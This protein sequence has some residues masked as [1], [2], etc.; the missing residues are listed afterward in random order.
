MHAAVAMTSALS[1][2]PSDRISSGRRQRTREAIVAAAAKALVERGPQALTVDD[3]LEAS[4]VARATFYK[5]FADKHEVTREVI[6][7]MWRRAADRY[8]GF[9]AG[10]PHTRASLRAW[11]EETAQTWREHYREVA[12][13]LREMPAEVVQASDGYL[14]DFAGLLVGDGGQWRCAQCEAKIRA[15]LLIG[16]LERAMLDLCRG[17]W[18][19]PEP[20]LLD[21]LTVLW[22]QALRAP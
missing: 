20:A 14:D 18:P 6:T 16:Q 5:H 9:S 3:I 21:T 12:A 10:P 17:S 4:G 2:P 7:R 15:G 19:V 8:A 22:L 1:P 11:M 13:L